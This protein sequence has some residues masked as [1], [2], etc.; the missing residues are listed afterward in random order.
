L[1]HF[2]EQL[3]H[4]VILHV[5]DDHGHRPAGIGYLRLP[6]RND[7][8]F[9][10]ARC[11]YM[12]S[13]PATTVSPAAVGRAHNCTSYTIVSKFDDACRCSRSLQLLTPFTRR[14]ATID[15]RP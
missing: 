12:P 4:H 2:Q 11:Y 6:A 13:M 7:H 9:I 15:A 8:G 5:A 14:L 10:M 1:W 3:D